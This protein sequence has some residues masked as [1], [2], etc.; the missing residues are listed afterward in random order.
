MPLQI[1]FD[2]KS[3]D[4][5]VAYYLID[6]FFMSDIFVTFFTTLPET[7][8]E[9][10]MTD[11]KVIALNYLKGWFFIDLMAIFPFDLLATLF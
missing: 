6:F 9:I 3:Y 2:Y 4:W 5:C 7:D 1:A 10:E 11:R 8:E